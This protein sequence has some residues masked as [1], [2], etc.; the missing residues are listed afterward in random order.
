MLYSETI[1]EGKNILFVHGN[2]QSL[3]IWNDVLANVLLQEY[4]LVAIDLPGHGKSFRSIQPE[5]D[6]ILKG[7]TEHLKNF[8]S[9]F[10]G[11]EF[12]FVAMSL[13]SNIVAE[14]DPFLENCKGVFFIGST[15]ADQTLTSNDLI[16][17]NPHVMP[18]FSSSTTDELLEGLINELMYVKKPETHK[19]YKNL[20]LNTDPAFRRC[21]G[22][23]LIKQEWSNEIGRLTAADIPVAIVYGESES[24]VHSNYLDNTALKKWH[25]QV[26]LIPNAKHCVEADQPDLLA[27]LIKEFAVECFK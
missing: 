17:P 1:G 2:S 6:Y 27:S 19:K 18:L 24:L 16:Q 11:K 23:S 7:L 3:E 25:D 26:I 15:I 13:G 4:Q 22:E 5:K 21:I 9:K 14:I 20:Y 10:D 12:I 8:T